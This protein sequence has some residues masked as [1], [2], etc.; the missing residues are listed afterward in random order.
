MI[1]DRR[2]LRRQIADLIAKLE[3]RPPPVVDA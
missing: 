3:K 2:E 1:V